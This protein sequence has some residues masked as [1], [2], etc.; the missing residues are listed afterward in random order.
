MEDKSYSLSSAI[1]TARL[2]PLE[3]MRDVAEAVGHQMLGT[4]AHEQ[5][6]CLVQRGAALRAG[7]RPRVVHRLSRLP[8]GAADRPRH[9][10]LEP[11]EHGA[12]AAGGLVGAV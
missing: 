10:V 12:A 3:Q 4:R 1:A 5:H 11:A 8:P 9:D 6:V 2:R 7:A